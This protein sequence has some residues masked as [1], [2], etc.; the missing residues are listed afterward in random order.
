MRYSL[1]GEWDLKG[2]EHGKPE[3]SLELSAQVPGNVELDLFR[4][5]RLVVKL[6]FVQIGVAAASAEV[7]GAV[8]GKVG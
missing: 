1:N 5:Q 7:P 2:F 8:E 3:P 4:A 6:D